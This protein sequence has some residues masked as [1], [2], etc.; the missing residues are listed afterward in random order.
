MAPIYA[1]LSDTYRHVTFTKVDVDA[2]QSVAQKYRVT[3]MP[4]FLF[5]KNKVV[6]GEVSLFRPIM[7]F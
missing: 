3:K 7:T 2:V 5:I 6:V 1:K 4:T